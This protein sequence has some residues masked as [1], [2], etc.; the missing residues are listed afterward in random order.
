[1]NRTISELSPSQRLLVALDD[2]VAKLEAQERSK[3][4][5][6]AIVGVGCRFP[7]ANNPEAFWQLLRSGT[8]AISEVPEKRWSLNDYYDPNPNAVGKIYTRYGGF[9]E[10]VDLFDPGFFNISPREAKSMDPQQRLLLEVS[11][12]TLENA[13]QI[14]K[15]LV[16]SKTGVFIGVTANDYARLLIPFDDYNCIDTYYL[17]GNPLNSMAGRL[18]Y[19]FGF[20]GP[21][22]AIDT[23]C[24]SSL[25]SVHLACQSLRNK[26]CNLALAG[27]VN[28][29]LSPEN[30]VALCKARMMA[31]DGHCKTF[32]ADADGYVRGEGCGL[33]LLKRFSDAVNAGDNILALVRGSAV[34]QDGSGSGFTVP[35]K[36]AQQDLITKA[37]NVAKINPLEIDYVQAH[38][39]GT[40]LGDPIEIRALVDALGKKRSHSNSLK[41]SSIKTNIGHLES[42]AG[43]AGLIAT[44]LSLRHQQI[45]PHL[46]FKKPN[47]FIDWNNI[48]VVIPEKLTSWSKE[49]K[50]RLAGVSSFGVSGTNAHL[51][52]EEFLDDK[53]I[54][55]KAR[56]P[57]HLLTLSAKTKE[58]LLDTVGQYKRLFLS[59]LS[60]KPEDICFSANTGRSHF[61][62]RM[63]VIAGSSNEFEK[64]LAEFEINEICKVTSTKTAFLFSGQGTQY[65]LMAQ[66]LYQTQPSFRHT[67]EQCDQILQSHLKQPLI[68]VIYPKNQNT[69]F[70]NQTEYT[71]PALFA[72]EYALAKLW[73]D[74]GIQPDLVIG[75][76]LG[77]YVA[78][79]I[80]GVFSLEDALMLVAQRAKLMQE[81]PPQGVMLAV[82]AEASAVAE[83][84]E[85]YLS[86]VNIAAVNSSDNIVLSGHVEAMK[87]VTTEL[88]AQGIELR[89]LNVSHA[90]H[91]PLMQPMLTEFERVAHR[92][93]YS[94]PKLKITSNVTGNIIGDEIAS[95]EYW[96]HH[97]TQTVQ[98]KTGIETLDREKINIL[99]EIGP[100]PV[101]LGMAR[102]IL[103]STEK[104]RLYLPSLSPRQS[105][106]QQIL[107]SLSQLYLHGA[108]IDWIAFNKDYPCR[109][110]S[111]PTYP[112]QRQSYW[113]EETKNPQLNSR[114]IQ[115]SVS[116][117]LNEGNS[118]SLV[119][120]LKNARNFSPEQQVLLPEIL[121]TLIKEHHRQLNHSSKENLY[122]LEWQFK[123][124]IQSV[125]EEFFQAKTW[126]ILAD[127]NGFA[128]A[129]AKRLKSHN[130][131]YILVYDQDIYSSDK[132]SSSWSVNSSKPED[133]KRLFADL[134]LNNKFSI[135]HIIHCWNLDVESPDKLTT[136]SLEK[137]QVKG[138]GSILNL[139]QSI[140][141]NNETMSP[142]LWLITSDAI[143][144]ERKSANIAQASAWG[145]CK[146]FGL[147]HPDNWGG[148]I[149]YDSNMSV[150]KAV[151]QILLEIEDNQGEELLALR[152]GKR[153]VARL[154]QRKISIPLKHQIVTNA[155]YLIT[156]GLG[157]LGLKIAQSLVERGA[158]CLILLSRKG[159][160]KE[161]EWS[162]LPHNSKIAKQIKAIKS[163]MKQ[164]VEVR[165]ET[166]DVADSEQMS[167]LFRKLNKQQYSLKG[168]VHAAGVENNQF[169]R[170]SSLEKLQ[171]AIKPKVLGAWLLHQLTANMELD[172]FVCFSSITSVWGSGKQANYAAANSFLDALSH[173]RQALKLPGLSINWGPWTGGGMTTKENQQLLHRIGVESWH[174]AVAIDIFDRLLECDVAQITA[175]KINWNIFK[176]VYQV[177]KERPLFDKIDTQ[178]QDQDSNLAKTSKITTQLQ[179]FQ[180]DQRYDFLVD[181]LQKKV[182]DILDLPPSQLPAEQDKFAELGMDSLTAVEL[183]NDLELDLGYSLSV[184][185]A[186]NYPSVGTLAKFILENIYRPNEL[187]SDLLKQPHKNNQEQKL[188]GHTVSLENMSEEDLASLLDEELKNISDLAL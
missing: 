117:L 51:I 160:P 49:G 135:G 1:M 87:S 41:V 184:T 67:I 147:E 61:T 143:A 42:A 70:I 106:W 127:H 60:I 90:F 18:S 3:S 138:C 66:Q 34:N 25:V 137:S 45:P 57:L 185:V 89:P 95:A 36:T 131:D 44:V 187:R 168:V 144:M 120:L 103:S 96:C 177:T 80:A 105:D 148:A 86:Q 118:H 73:Q 33:V 133:F 98:F 38:G 183:K 74:W 65:V 128:K 56:R 172:F 142:Q 29:I 11:W 13:G 134:K 19:T 35:N 155:A 114:H 59:N 79:T 4:E 180:P 186:F 173:Y 100:K 72:I 5:P 161:D 176:P 181:F 75:H 139:A 111:L 159:L 163:L 169:I 93:N 21:S 68:S 132:K 174:P 78:A 69:N 153:Y 104:P 62:H 50:S 166:A 91:S 126:L 27:G 31:N 152:N 2:A 76:S 162:C 94:S 175:A 55:V 32:D 52:L 85:P 88:E 110:V 178:C 58:A 109:R 20:Q 81:L 6:I 39:T 121:E 122:Q 24:S 82:F 182:A 40:S 130:Q 116:N 92:V 107:H 146:V 99:I 28:L 167:S 158:R 150:E 77:E 15:K 54:S 171:Y 37:L 145:F 115:T 43:I 149:D 48:P 123:A 14:P 188:T 97:I 10:N 9:I 16:D 53:E 8:D 47:S 63:S 7:G 101:L 124:R 23:A 64:K 26:E 46:H 30:T 165:I 12:E 136:S 179:N 71:Q 113:F 119:T 170:D 129:L 156:G 151:T 84:I 157:F 108:S 164:G 125:R 102:S 22:M 17:T 140:I 112:F 141:S 154:V 83:I